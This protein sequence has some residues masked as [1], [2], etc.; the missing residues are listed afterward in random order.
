MIARL[1]RRFLYHNP[2]GAY[3]DDIYT[4]CV[5]NGASFRVSSLNDQLKSVSGQLSKMRARG[6]VDYDLHGNQYL[7]RLTPAGR[8]YVQGHD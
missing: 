6:L 3:T 8:L 5:R 7:W 1:I 4:Y 2:G